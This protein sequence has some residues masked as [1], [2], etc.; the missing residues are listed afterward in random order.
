MFYR[1]SGLCSNKECPFLHI[2]PEKKIRDC[3][4]YDRGFCRHGKICIDRIFNYNRIVSVHS[5]VLCNNQSVS[6]SLGSG[7]WVVFSRPFLVRTNPRLESG[8]R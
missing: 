8:D 1:I 6:Q 5:W 3:P 4:W 7:D 2:D